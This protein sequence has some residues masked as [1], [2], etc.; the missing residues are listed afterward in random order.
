MF[1]CGEHLETWASATCEHLLQY[2][3]I[4]LPVEKLPDH[5]RRYLDFQGTLTENRGTVAR[6]FEG[7]YEVDPRDATRR[8][9]EFFSADESAPVIR[10]WQI[11]STPTGPQLQLQ[12][13]DFG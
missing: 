3:S 12:K 13:V 6:E 5:R 7:N 11:I 1:D 8:Q 9:L 4:E 2:D 10:S